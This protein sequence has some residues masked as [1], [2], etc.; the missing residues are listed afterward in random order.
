MLERLGCCSWSLQPDSPE[1]LA[2]KLR[3]IGV[4]RVQLALE[5]LR[6]GRWALKP[7]LD[8][9]AHVGVE[10]RSGMMETTGE[11]YSTLASI[12]I[13]GGIR[14]DRHWAANLERA[15]G[16][17]R[18]ARELGL[19]LVTF[20]AGFLP[21][22]PFDP[23]RGRLLARLCT[24]ADV[25]AEHGVAV[26]FETGQET[27]ET[28]LSVL[29]EVDR[30]TV[31]IN[32]DPANMVLYGMGDPVAALERLAPYVRQLHFKDAVATRVKGTWGEE[33]PV[34]DGDVDWRALLAVVRRHRLDVDC[35]FEREAGGDRIGD[36]KRGA[37]FIAGLVDA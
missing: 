21:H 26:G 6:S 31:G 23:E 28:L 14:P 12:A 25:F 22:D 3:A 4:K 24:I 32:F 9:L 5:P 16:C 29:E 36:L 33:V 7:T 13:T 19:P 1:D 11:D 15:E 17:A 27:A 10:I 34:G 37:S 18:L 30:P 8:A 20:H 2:L 35:M